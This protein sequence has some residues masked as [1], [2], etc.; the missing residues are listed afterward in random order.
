M[1]VYAT[2]KSIYNFARYLVSLF[3]K[4]REKKIILLKKLRNEG[5]QPF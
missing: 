5:V 1:H 4:K 3:E 2:L